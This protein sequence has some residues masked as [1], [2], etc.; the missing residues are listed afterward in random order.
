MSIGL[1]SALARGIR[2]AALIEV[3]NKVRGKRDIELY[4][5]VELDISGE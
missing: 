4:C 3:A 1:S 2:K 5:P